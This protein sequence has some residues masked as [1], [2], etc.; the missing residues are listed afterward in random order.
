MGMQGYLLTLTSQTEQD[1]VVSLIDQDTWVG[2]TYEP[3]Y[4]TGLT[5]TE[6]PNG[7]ATTALYGS[8]QAR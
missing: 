1:F 8:S 3:S 5:L 6:G 2:G 7:P 4:L